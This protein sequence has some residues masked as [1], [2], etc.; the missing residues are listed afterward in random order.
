MPFTG[1]SDFFSSIHEDGINAIVQN[2]MRQRPSLFNY[3]TSAFHTDPDLFCTEIDATDKV[4]DAGNPLFTEQEPLPILGAPIPIGLNFCVQFTNAELDFHPGNVIDLPPELHPLNEQ[5]FAVTLSVC[6][7]IDC[8]AK[9]VI[10]EFLPQ[11]EVTL[12]EEQELAVGTVD[13]HKPRTDKDEK[14][15]P[16]KEKEPVIP[17]PPTRIICFCLSLYAVGHFEW[18][19]VPTSNQSW[20]KTKLD[21]LEIV[22]ISPTRMENSLE[23]YASTVLRLGILPRVM[24]P[25]EKMVL[26]ITDQMAKWG[27]TLGKQVT[28]E[29]SSVPGDVPHN[30]SIEKDRIQTHFKL[31]V[32]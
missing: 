4:K 24:V 6:V 2:L 21:G 1:A 32:T 14:D 7:G 8:P 9:K 5:R 11:A 18:G 28:I 17:L 3:A 10:D 31:V 20:L 12:L 30:P 29:P 15:K 23:C 19:T 22:D 25:V 16:D 27:V 26:D 13:E